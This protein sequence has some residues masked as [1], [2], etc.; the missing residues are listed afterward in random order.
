MFF[1]TAY[2]VVGYNLNNDHR[3]KDSAIDTPI[4][5]SENMRV[6]IRSDIEFDTIPYFVP[7]Y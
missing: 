4:Y 7:V 1:R 6:Q 5:S 3:A 2:Q